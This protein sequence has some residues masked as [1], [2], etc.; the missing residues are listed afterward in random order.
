VLKNGGVLCQAGVQKAEN[1]MIPSLRFDAGKKGPIH[2]MQFN[3]SSALSLK[4]EN[5]FYPPRK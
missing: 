5:G 2:E 3:R 4:R 1:E